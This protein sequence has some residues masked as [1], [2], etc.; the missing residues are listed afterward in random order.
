MEPQ[1]MI[2]FFT[3]NEL[4]ARAIHTE[5]V[6]VYGPETLALTTVKK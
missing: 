4:K 1:A 3:L 6:S 5:L 2:R